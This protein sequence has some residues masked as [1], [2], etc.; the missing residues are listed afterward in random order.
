MLF[1][2]A[3]VSDSKAGFDEII[4]GMHENKAQKIVAVIC[5]LPNSEDLSLLSNG[6]IYTNKN[7][8]IV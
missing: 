6:V 4:V 3:Q 2:Q 5:F 8:P 1:L 7:Y